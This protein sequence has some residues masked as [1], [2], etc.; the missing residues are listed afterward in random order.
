MQHCRAAGQARELSRDHQSEGHVLRHI[1]AVRRRGA[2]AVMSRLVHFLVH[3]RDGAD[4]H[5]ERQVEMLENVTHFQ[6]QLLGDG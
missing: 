2:C 3:L 6:V 5:M 4:R 1:A